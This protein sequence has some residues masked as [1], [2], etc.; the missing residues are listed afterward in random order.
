MTT[1]ERLGSFTP[2]EL[3]RILADGRSV[4]IRVD[5]APG[6]IWLE[7]TGVAG[8]KND[9]PG[10][11][12]RAPGRLK[13]ILSRR[14]QPDLVVPLRITTRSR[15]PGWAALARTPEIK[16]VCTEGRRKLHKVLEVLGQVIDTDG[17]VDAVEVI[18]DEPID[19]RS[20]WARI[21]DLLEL[22]SSESL[23]RA[24]ARS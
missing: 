7:Y 22:D 13:L 9:G 23:R 21:L 6:N 4:M 3:F 11:R 24:G 2:D 16:Q 10:E 20:A 5:W 17:D 1:D 8:W 14:G 15:V 18:A 12:V 19:A